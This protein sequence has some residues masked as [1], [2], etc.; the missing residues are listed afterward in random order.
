M[1]SW[2]LMPLEGQMG[3]APCF[4]ELPPCP[5]TVQGFLPFELHL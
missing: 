1:D 2:G 5:G 3:L 4:M